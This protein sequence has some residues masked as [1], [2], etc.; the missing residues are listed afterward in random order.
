MVALNPTFRFVVVQYDK[1]KMNTL[2]HSLS[3]LIFLVYQLQKAKNGAIMCV[4]H[5]FNRIICLIFIF[6]FMHFSLPVTLIWK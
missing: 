5:I 4:V 2:N 3:G 1:I 6:C